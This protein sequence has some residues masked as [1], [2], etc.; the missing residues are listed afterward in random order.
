MREG[1]RG[2]RGLGRYIGGVQSRVA[3]GN[4]A[5]QRPDNR[6]G[7]GGRTGA[8]QSEFQPAP[9]AEPRSATTSC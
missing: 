2:H 9:S 7:A 1:G 8:M 3:A 6:S 4:F 5:K